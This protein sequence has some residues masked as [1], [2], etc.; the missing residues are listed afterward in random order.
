MQLS[1]SDLRTK[2]VINVTDG[3][4]LGKVCD[5]VFC[6]PENKV[7][8][9]VVPGGK[10]LSFRRGEVFIELKCISKMGEDV[11]LVNVPPFGK[12]GKPQER[13][14]GQ[15]RVCTPPPSPPPPPP[16]P[17]YGEFWEGPPRRSYEEYE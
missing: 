3:K 12:G 16:P 11:I 1:F 13:G 15:P 7:L 8:G 4:K 6:Y 10:G 5:L 14:K 17:Q 9:I 2:E